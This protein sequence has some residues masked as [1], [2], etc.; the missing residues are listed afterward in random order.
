MGIQGKFVAEI[1][2]D[3]ILELIASLAPED[4]FLDFKEMIFHPGHSKP[5]DEIEDLMADLTAFAN[6][7]GGHIVIG[8][9]GANYNCRCCSRRAIARIDDHELRGGARSEHDILCASHS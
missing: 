9:Q 2:R 8:I 7:F 6:A 1:T 5:N 4:V 3:D